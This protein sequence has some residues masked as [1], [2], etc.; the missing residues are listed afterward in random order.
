[1][2][3][4]IHLIDVTDFTLADGSKSRDWFK[5]A[6]EALHIFDEIDLVVHDGV[7]G[8][9]PDPRAVAVRG[10]GVIVS[11]SY[12]TVYAKKR[13]IPPLL[14]FIGEVDR[15]GGSVLGICFGHHALAVALGG[16]VV[17]NP[18]G[19]E[20][21]TVP[22]YLTPE[23][24]KSLLLKGF[25]SGDPVNLVHRTHVSRLPAGAVRLAFN[26]MTPNQAFRSGRSFG[27]Q[28]H[29]EFTPVQ[30]IQLTDKYKNVLVRRE[31][32]L[33]DYE[34]VENFKR[35]FRETPSSRFVLRNYVRMIGE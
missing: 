4:V 30:L 6:F 19:R 1:M 3:T 29:P 20:M 25:S 21:G 14:R 17:A 9:L 27:Y 28:P 26:Q 8:D 10:S 18:R 15:E 33:D 22:I 24:E 11:G 13:W 7:A 23:G 2:K 12:G 16:E 5:E 32:F 31:K 34:H 35:S